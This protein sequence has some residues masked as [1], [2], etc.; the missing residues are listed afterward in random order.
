MFTKD[1]FDSEPNL[2]MN[3]LET[4]SIKNS[5]Q[6][7][8]DMPQQLALLNKWSIPKVPTNTLYEYGMFD[9]YLV[10]QVVKTTEQSIA[11]NS[12]E[13]V[14]QLL[15]ATD[16]ESY[17]SH[18]NYKFMHIGLV[19]IA[20]KPLTLEG[21]PESFV[22]ALRDGR[23]LHWKKSLMGI[24]QSS[25]AHGPVYF[26]VYPNLQLSLSDVN[27]LDALTLNVKLHGYNYLPGSELI[28]LHY[29]ICF[30]LL[31]TLTPR[32]KIISKPSDETILIETNFYKSQIS[33]RKTIKWEEIEFP[34][35]WQINK[36]IKRNSLTHNVTSCNVTEI[37]QSDNGQI[38][39]TFDKPKIPK[40][41]RSIS[42][43]S[44]KSYIDPVDSHKFSTS[45]IPEIDL[46]N[47][48]NQVKID[49]YNIVR[50]ADSKTFDK[51]MPSPSEMGYHGEY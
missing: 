17:R 10:K 7:E 31:N 47:R 24:I 28:C 44:F 9:R 37:E 19:Q 40:L 34:E 45:S 4:T 27:I 16:I 38:S 36:G 5:V 42:Q 46:T 6:E 29:R 41:L 48:I 20:F 49:P 1:L 33:T 30:K 13:R 50:S 23:N 8:Y 51:D 18:K 21:L 2:K 15:S 14:L 43:R 26:N 12:D 11:L 3:N 22:A 35:S 25:L 39:I 32:C